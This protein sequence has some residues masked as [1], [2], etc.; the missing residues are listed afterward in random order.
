[1]PSVTSGDRDSGHLAAADPQQLTAPVSEPDIPRFVGI[2]NR[3][4]RC[5]A[6]GFKHRPGIAGAQLANA[7]EAVEPDRPVRPGTHAHHPLG[8]QFD[9]RFPG[10]EGKV[11]RLIESA[12]GGKPKVASGIDRRGLDDRR[13]RGPVAPQTARLLA[14]LPHHAVRLLAAEPDPAVEIFH[15]E[16]RPV[17]QR[18]IETD[19]LPPLLVRP[20]RRCRSVPSPAVC[21][22]DARGTCPCPESAPAS[23]GTNAPSRN[24]A[25]GAPAVA[26]QIRPSRAAH[27]A[28]T[29]CADGLARAVRHRTS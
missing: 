7:A 1:M 19:S 4:L 15:R 22:R 11:A 3:Q 12:E 10:D 26:T 5:R 25:T 6:D 18:W 13:Q 24:S 23:P 9:G 27:A 20:A 17:A 29:V 21:H 2:A 28:T 14:L 8:R 16:G